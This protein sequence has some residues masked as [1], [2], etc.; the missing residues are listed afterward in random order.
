MPG[1]FSGNLIFAIIAR[2]LCGN[3]LKRATSRLVEHLE[4][5]RLNFSSLSLVI[6]V[7]LLHPCSFMVYLLFLWCFSILA[8]CY[9]QVSFSL[10]V[11][12]YTG[13]IAQNTVTVT[14]PL[15]IY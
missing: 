6:R 9:F 11:I 15:T 2:M 3:H 1:G 12:L 8:N 13:K 14:E 4:K 5:F 10:K 7:N